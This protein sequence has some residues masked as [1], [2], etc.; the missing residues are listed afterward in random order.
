MRPTAPPLPAK[1]ERESRGQADYSVLCLSDGLDYGEGAAFAASLEKLAGSAGSIAVLRP[2]KDDAAL[3]LGQ[4]EG[5]AASLS[6][7]F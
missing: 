7:A 4:A 3:A 6:H 2:G 5:E 1:L